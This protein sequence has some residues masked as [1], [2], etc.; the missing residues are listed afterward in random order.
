LPGRKKYKVNYWGEKKKEGKI[1]YQDETFFIF[2]W[3]DFSWKEF[4]WLGRLFQ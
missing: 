4:F 2:F 1:V 3:Q